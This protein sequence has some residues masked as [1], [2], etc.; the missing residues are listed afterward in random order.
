MFDKVLIVVGKTMSGKTHFVNNYLVPKGYNQVITHT[1]R[2]KR[3]TE[4]N[5]SYFFENEINQ[6]GLALREYDM[7]DG[8]V[9]YWTTKED[10]LS[11]EHP[12]IIIDIKGAIEITKELGEENVRIAYVNEKDTT[13]LNRIN[14]SDRGNTEDIKESMRRYEDDLI[15][16]EK[17]DKKFSIQGG[18]NYMTGEKFLW[19]NR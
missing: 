10:I 8:H 19:I 17:M 15:Q 16:F 18:Y 1:T 12:V 6:S 5:N 9:G 2:P 14:N 3:I 4:S 11:T 13:I 7:I